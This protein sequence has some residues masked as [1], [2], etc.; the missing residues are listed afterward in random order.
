MASSLTATDTIP[1]GCPQCQCLDDPGGFILASRRTYFTPSVT[2]LTCAVVHFDGMQWIDSTAV[3]DSAQGPVTADPVECLPVVAPAIPDCANV[4]DPEKGF[5][6]FTDD[7]HSGSVASLTCSPYPAECI[8]CVTHSC[9]DGQVE[10]V[11]TAATAHD[12]I[13][14]GCPMCLCQDDSDGATARSRP[15]Y[16]TPSVPSLHCEDFGRH[17][18]QWADPYSQQAIHARP[19]CVAIHGG[20]FSAGRRRVQQADANAVAPC[21]T[22][23]PIGV[24]VEHI[25]GHNTGGSDFDVITDKVHITRGRRG[26]GLYNMVSESRAANEGGPSPV[27]TMWARGSVAT[28]SPSSYRSFQPLTH[29]HRKNLS[30]QSFAVHLVEDDLHFDITFTPCMTPGAHFATCGWSTPGAFRYTRTLRR[31]PTGCEADAFVPPAGTTATGATS[32][33]TATIPVLPPAGVRAPPPP[34]PPSPEPATQGNVDET[35]MSGSPASPTVPQRGEPCGPD[36]VRSWPDVKNDLVCGECTAFVANFDTTYLGL[37]SN[38][39]QAINRPCLNAWEEVD[40]TC[41]RESTQTCTG[42]WSST[43]DALCECG[44]EVR[45]PP[46]IPVARPPPPTASGT[47]MPSPPKAAVAIAP[48]PPQ[49]WPPPSPAPPFVEYEECNNCDQPYDCND[50][51]DGALLFDAPETRV[52]NFFG[53]IALLSFLTLALTSLNYVRRNHYEIFYWSHMLCL[54]G[55]VGGLYNHHQTGNLDLVAPY[56]ALIFLDYFLRAVRLFVRAAGFGAGDATVSAAVTIDAGAGGTEGG[57]AISIELLM[58]RRTDIEAGQYFFLCVPS[59]SVCQWHPFSVV[60]SRDLDDGAGTVVEIAVKGLG[61]WSN[62]L[63]D[64]GVAGLIDRRVLMDGPYG[65]LAVRPERYTHTAVF[66]AGVG[67]TPFLGLLDELQHA[68]NEGRSL[69]SSIRFVWSLREESL[70]MH[71]L[72]LLQRAADNG[73]HIEVYLTGREKVDDDCDAPPAS[74]D[75]EPHFGEVIVH[76]GRPDIAAHLEAVA[77]DYKTATGSQ[78]GGVRG[79]HAGCAVLAC[80]P[81][82]FVQSV[83]VHCATVQSNKAKA[84]AEAEG[85]VTDF[86][87]LRASMTDTATV[88]FD[89]HT[90]VF[91]F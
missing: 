38:Y 21:P 9:D 58:K 56:V 15:L 8:H 44:D 54:C 7:L 10:V 91:E 3:V 86:S 52:Q 59:V 60:G 82:G 18:M 24:E 83:I 33:T 28:A 12:E 71:Y 88:T 42:W 22:A 47:P 61:G 68:H 85:E 77:A 89:V 78:R 66:C 16:F 69:C 36:V 11:A 34:A 65:E 43:S 90:E 73:A 48:P 17:G 45:A 49:V 14:E 51:P 1:T 25:H 5:F 57:G 30:G 6:E 67:C 84:V 63:V 87:D 23:T 79:A 76:S 75:G 40:N 50:G 13:T 20:H 37:C 29:G 80:G 53:L 27:G 81:T 62:A 74:P 64:A 2:S 72:P 55:V 70:F 32:P 41:Q 46:P 4:L 31:G 26:Q 35:M 39:C 19:T